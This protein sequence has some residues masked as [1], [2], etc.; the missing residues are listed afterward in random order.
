MKFLLLEPTW[1]WSIT[2]IL[3]KIG[4]KNIDIYFALL[5]KTIVV[6]FLCFFII[7]F[8]GE[9]NQILLINKTTIIFL[10]LSGITTTLLW[11]CYLKALNLGEV[12]KVSSA[13]PFLAT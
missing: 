10:F 9:L 5:L 12:S 4:T 2:T 3:S 13:M 8:E 6:F 7:L 11:I 1:L